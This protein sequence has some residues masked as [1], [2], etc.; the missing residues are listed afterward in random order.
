MT[1]LAVPTTSLKGCTVH[2]VLAQFFSVQS[3]FGPIIDDSAPKNNC[4]G[5]EIRGPNRRIFKDRIVLEFR[6]QI[7]P[8]FTVTVPRDIAGIYCV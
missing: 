7:D 3:R 5:P 2:I 6:G 4:F 1:F 8:K